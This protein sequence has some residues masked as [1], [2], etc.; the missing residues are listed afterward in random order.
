MA[1]FM[2]SLEEHRLK[3]PAC[4]WLK[5]TSAERGCVGCNH[6]LL[7]PCLVSAQISL[8]FKKI[9]RE[10]VHFGDG[11]SFTIASLVEHR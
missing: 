11:L 8:S 10:I 6:L 2:G 4:C 1:L 5:I 7:L 3:L 9:P